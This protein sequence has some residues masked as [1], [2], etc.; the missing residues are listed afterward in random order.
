MAG[1]LHSAGVY[2]TFS[3]GPLMVAAARA[4]LHGS[5][6]CVLKENSHRGMQAA[7]TAVLSAFARQNDTG[8]VAKRKLTRWTVVRDSI[9]PRQFEILSA[10]DQTTVTLNGINAQSSGDRF[11]GM[12]DSHPFR[13]T[14][15]TPTPAW[16]SRTATG[17]PIS[18][19]V[20]TQ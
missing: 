18:S 4:C 12:A 9:T 15:V 2:E 14:E 17:M 6:L 8:A 20:S 10:F 16:S 13:H 1:Y 19:T 3:V 11:S 5:D 7:R